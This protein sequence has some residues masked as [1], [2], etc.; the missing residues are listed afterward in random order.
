MPNKKTFSLTN[1][2]A[3]L[4]EIQ[5]PTTDTKKIT[6]NSISKVLTEILPKA[7]LQRRQP[8]KS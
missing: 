6:N 7:P 2:N 8:S 1:F 3:I 4:L 5:T